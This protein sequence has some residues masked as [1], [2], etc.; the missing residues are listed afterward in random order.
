MFVVRSRFV[1]LLGRC[2]GG[3]TKTSSS[4][5]CVRRDALPEGRGLLNRSGPG[6]RAVDPVEGS[7][8]REDVMTGFVRRGDEFVDD[9]DSGDTYSRRP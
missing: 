9:S 3:S 2:W 6:S 4:K 7:A 5:G 8:S 1:A